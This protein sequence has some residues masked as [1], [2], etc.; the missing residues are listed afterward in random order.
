MKQR[1]I[2]TL[3][4]F[5]FRP[6]FSCSEKWSSHLGH[7]C[8]GGESFMKSIL[9]CDEIFNTKWLFCDQTAI[10]FILSQIPR[11]FIYTHLRVSR[12]EFRAT[13]VAP[14]TF[15]GA[16]VAWL[17]SSGLSIWMETPAIGSVSKWF[18]TTYSATAVWGLPLGPPF[19]GPRQWPR[20]LCWEFRLLI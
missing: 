8:T 12:W 5:V 2:R 15:R 1:A 13:L 10:I 11:L 9:H 7:V 20:S 4:P 17:S 3:L 6:Y 16:P 18:G 19:W 14:P